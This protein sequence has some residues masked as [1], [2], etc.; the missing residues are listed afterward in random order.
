MSLNDNA[1]GQAKVQGQLLDMMK[2]LDA[3][4]RKHGIQYSLLGGSMLGAVREH[5]F[6]PWDDDLDLVFTRE[7]LER[8]IAVFPDESEHLAVNTTDTWVARIVTKQPIDGQIPFIDLFHYD[9]LPKDGRARNRKLLTLQLLQ[10][11]LKHD[12]DYSRYTFKN[13]I[14][15]IGTHLI[16]LMFTRKRK[17]KWYDAVARRGNPADGQYHVSDDQFHCLGIAYDPSCAQHFH[18]TPFEDT[19]LML[20]DGYDTML[21]AQYGDDYMTPPPMEQRAPTHEAQ[22]AKGGVS[23][24]E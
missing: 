23:A 10:G 16:G 1:Y 24:H 8:L 17:L 22:R 18:D 21:R 9:W 5:G 7:A 3:V 6:I 20:S 15:L 14:L 19:A 11:M 13:R 4:C 12:T 2:E